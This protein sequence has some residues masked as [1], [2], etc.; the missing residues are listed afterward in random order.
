MQTDVVT[1]NQVAHEPYC[2]A[3][4]L[5]I[6]K[7]LVILVCRSKSPTGLMLHVVQ[8]PT[9]N[10][11]S[12]SMSNVALPIV[13]DAIVIICLDNFAHWVLANSLR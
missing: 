7:M 8:Y 3:V 6:L 13:T 5:V 1:T 2:P 11:I 4:I 9:Q 12:M 10:K